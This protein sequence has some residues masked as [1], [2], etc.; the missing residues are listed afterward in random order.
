M[1]QL[2]I[3]LAVVVFSMAGYETQAQFM[4][5]AGM[6]IYKTDHDGFGEK[7]QIGIEGNYFLTRSFTVL[8]GIEFWSAGPSSQIIFGSRWYIVDQVYLK[9]RGLM[10]HT[11]DVS[12]G[13]GHSQAFSR[14]WR[15]DIGGD[16]FYNSK[17]MAFRL[18]LGYVF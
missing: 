16:Y 15:F 7:T 14:N 2:Y 1:K 18:G 9:F 13:M 10:S 17:E 11:A 5:S 6:D 3:V 12:L 8:G 4:L